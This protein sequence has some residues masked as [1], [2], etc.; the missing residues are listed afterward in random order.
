MNINSGLLKGSL[1]A[2]YGN[3]E[4]PVQNGLPDCDSVSSRLCLWRSTIR[5]PPR[6]IVC[7]FFVALLQIL[8]L[9]ARG[10]TDA[11]RHMGTNT[12]GAQTN[13][14]SGQTDPSPGQTDSSLAQTDSS[15]SVNL[16]RLVIVGGTT[17]VAVTAI[18]IYQQNSWWRDYR[19]S[20]HFRE[21]L[22]Y[23]MYMDKLGHLY[24]SSVMTFVFSKSLQWCN[25]NEPSS[26]IWGAVGSTLF[27]TYVEIEDGFSAYWGFDR[28]DY[29]A[30][31]FGAWYP[32]LQ[33]HVPVFKNFQFRFSYL[34]KNEGSA[35]AIPGQTKT[36]FDDYE[37]QT[38]WLTVTPKGLFSAK[39]LRWWPDWLA[40]AGGVAVR[41]NN[42][43]DR[44]LVWFLAPDLDM[45]K[46]I[47]QD[48]P[49]LRSLGEALNFIHFPMPAVQVS[50]GVVWYGLYF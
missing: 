13:P 45:T 25:M 24:A 50:P 16:T 44:Y 14:S 4:A 15:T 12:P 9:A 5:I 28:V 43:P 49:F 31:L 19:T 40:V 6:M 27:Q 23:A 22:E 17:A 38:F 7:L 30:N 8:T 34:P 2:S 3:A 29:A 35:G 18:H 47:P 36:M 26:L 46:I 37:G 1:A 48:T 11:S 21:D 33:Y 42:S 10:Q 41:N 32:V 20:F 39:S